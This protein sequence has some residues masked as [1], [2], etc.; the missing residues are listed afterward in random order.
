MHV[1]TC[2]IHY[3]FAIPLPTCTCT[4]PWS[5]VSRR[6][7]KSKRRM[8]VCPL[9]L[10]IFMDSWSKPLSHHRPLPSIDAC[11]WAHV[12]YMLLKV[13]SA[14]LAMTLHQNLAQTEAILRDFKLVYEP[15]LVCAFLWGSGWVTV[16][17]FFIC[18]QA[19][20]MARRFA[21]WLTYL[22]AAVNHKG[23]ILIRRVQHV[24]RFTLK[25]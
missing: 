4:Q 21:T 9:F 16:F 10:C 11:V 18:W 19:I 14:C 24:H 23:I 5:I 20:V 17:L 15:T 13:K 22:A 1:R 2:R 3:M 8:I 6:K 25:E 7:R 12:M